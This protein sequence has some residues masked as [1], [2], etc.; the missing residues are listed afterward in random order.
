[1]P[2]QEDEVSNLKTK[3]MIMCCLFRA[4]THSDIFVWSNG[5]MMISKGKS[6]K[7]GE[8]P[9]SVPLHLP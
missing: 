2:G 5:G 6:K 8:K 4:I 3:D 7:F 9:A 1:V